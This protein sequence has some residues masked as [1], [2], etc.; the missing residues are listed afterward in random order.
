[1]AV[2]LLSVHLLLDQSLLHLHPTH[3]TDIPTYVLQA[4]AS[5]CSYQR[6]G[7]GHAPL[8]VSMVTNKPS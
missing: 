1:M 4:P 3:L 8:L 6:G 5:E 7:E 2:L